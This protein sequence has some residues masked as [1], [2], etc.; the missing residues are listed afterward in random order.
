MNFLNLKENSRMIKPSFLLIKTVWGGRWGLNPRQP[1]SQSGTL[2]T[3]LR[4]P[5]TNQP[6]TKKKKQQTSY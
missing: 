2:P 3:E 6:T 1:E 5:H 4:P